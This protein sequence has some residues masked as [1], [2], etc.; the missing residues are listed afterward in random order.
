M[1][2][3]QISQK[4]NQQR[5][6]QLYGSVKEFCHS[7]LIGYKF[8]FFTFQFL[9]KLKVANDYD[10]QYPMK[11][12]GLSSGKTTISLTVTLTKSSPAMSD[13][14]TW[15][16]RS[17]ISDWMSSTIFGS[18]CFSFS[19]VMTGSC[20][21]SPPQFSFSLLFAAIGGLKEPATLA[22]LGTPNVFLA[23]PYDE[24]EMSLLPR[25]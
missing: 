14:S 7:V 20:L 6:F 5:K 3:F 11:M 16:P 17:M 2:K 10:F 22:D 19:L 13:H 8:K 24:P 9:F 21:T 1:N 12:S 25:F 4:P 18:R 23:V 15:V